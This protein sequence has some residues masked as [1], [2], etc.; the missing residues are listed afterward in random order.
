MWSKVKYY[1]FILVRKLLIYLS[2]E[3]KN[4]KIIYIVCIIKSLNKIDGKSIKNI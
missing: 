4:Y 3:S 2:L 1:L